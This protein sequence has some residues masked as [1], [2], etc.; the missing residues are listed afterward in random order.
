LPLFLHPPGKPP[1][2]PQFEH[3]MLADFYKFRP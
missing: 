3:P 1:P 2:E